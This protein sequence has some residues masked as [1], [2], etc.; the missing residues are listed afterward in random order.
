MFSTALP[1]TLL[2]ALAVAAPT[3]L[4]ARDGSGFVSVGNKYS[5]NGC[6]SNQLIF[7]DPIFGDGN[8]CQ[9]LDRFGTSPPILSYETL[10]VN[11]N[12][13]GKS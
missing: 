5:G 13:S 8:S 10:S 3:T 6:N 4:E 12:C 9:A 7:A 11:A 2:T 1:I